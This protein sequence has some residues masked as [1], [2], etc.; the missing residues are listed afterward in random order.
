MRSSILV[1]LL[2]AVAP[3]LVAAAPGDNIL[4]EDPGLSV[5]N[6]KYT[7]D[8]KPAKT[9]KINRWGPSIPVACK[10]EALKKRSDSNPAKKCEMNKMDVFQVW[11]DDAPEPWVVCRCQDQPMTEA[12]SRLLKLLAPA[13][14]SG[15]NLVVCIDV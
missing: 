12:V 8:V 14:K 2:S 6:D 13:E 10:E 5:L 9:V 1:A 15:R 4:F 11:F 3:A 7:N